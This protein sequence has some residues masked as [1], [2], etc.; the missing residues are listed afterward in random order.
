MAE[1]G[2]TAPVI[3]ASHAILDPDALAGTQIDVLLRA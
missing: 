2:V 1:D 3:A